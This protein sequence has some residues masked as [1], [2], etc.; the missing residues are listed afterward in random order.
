M[1]FSCS[2]AVSKVMEPFISLTGALTCHSVTKDIIV[3][4]ITIKYPVSHLNQS[5]ST[6]TGL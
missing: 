4:S 1:T 2:L 3:C 5:A 6:I